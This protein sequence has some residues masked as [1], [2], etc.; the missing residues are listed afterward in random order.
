MTILLLS[1]VINMIKSG[2][3]AKSIQNL[4]PADDIFTARISA[5]MCCCTIIYVSLCIGKRLISA[6][7]TTE[8]R[9]N[10][11]PSQRTADAGDGESASVTGWGKAYGCVAAPPAAQRSG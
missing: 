6:G 10:R 3:L 8:G 11:T 7:A 9:G 1:N 2:D 4:K 5:C